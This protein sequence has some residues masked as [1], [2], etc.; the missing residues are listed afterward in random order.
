MYA[1]TPYADTPYVS[2]GEE[3]AAPVYGNLGP[4]RERKKRKSTFAA[5]SLREQL[6]E[7]YEAFARSSA[8]SP[9]P[10][11]ADRVS[12]LAP[13][14]EKQLEFIKAPKTAGSVPQMDWA[15]ATQ[16]APDST[17]EQRVEATP[18]EVTALLQEIDE[19]ERQRKLAKQRLQRSLLLG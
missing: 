7:T 15:A 2:F 13:V 14:P 16:I 10:E 11:S 6:E 5:K 3:E 19:L 17:T 18:A 1:D 12:E 4:S 8:S 9:V